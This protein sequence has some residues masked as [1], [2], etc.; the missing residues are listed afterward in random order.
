MKVSQSQTPSR[1][2]SRHS[3]PLPEAFIVFVTLLI[4]ACPALAQSAAQG[5][6]APPATTAPATAPPRLIITEIFADPLLQDDRAGEFVEVANVGARAASMAGVQLVLPSGRALVLAQPGNG[7]LAAGG[8]LVL[9][10]MANHPGSQHLPGLKLPNRAGRLEL[11]WR[12][13]VIDVAQWTPKWPWPKHR[14]GWSLER[15]GVGVDGRV[16]RGW[17]HCRVVY[18]GVERA[19]P[20]VLPLGWVGRGARQ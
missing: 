8:V 18:H 10:P 12:G 6:P 1:N 5:P 14:V 3:I 16:G 20:G 9:R 7:G 17:R 4:T 19:S 13:R 2:L 15:R 11:R